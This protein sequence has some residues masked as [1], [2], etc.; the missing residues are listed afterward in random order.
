M[1]NQTQLSS[2]KIANFRQKTGSFSKKAALAMV[3]ATF[4]AATQ[5]SAR[6][7]ECSPGETCRPYYVAWKNAARRNLPD[8]ENG[9]LKD[10]TCIQIS[11]TGAF[12]KG[13][14]KTTLEFTGQPVKT[15]PPVYQSVSPRSLGLLGIPLS[16]RNCSKQISVKKSTCRRW[17]LL[18]EL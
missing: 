5:L 4:P 17:D 11:Q 18:E 14:E 16:R 3:A 7:E 10:V 8:C 6:E 13:R 1:A 2:L 9:H 12:V 15:R